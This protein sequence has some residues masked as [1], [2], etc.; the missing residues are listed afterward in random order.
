VVSQDVPGYRFVPP[1][2]V[3]SPDNP[4]NK[5]FCVS[6]PC[7]VP[8]GLFNMSACQFDSPTLISW[9]HFFQADPKLLEAVEGLDPDQEKHQFFM[10]LQP[11]LGTGLR[12]QARSQ[13]NIKLSD[14]HPDIKPAKGL[15]DIVFPFL[16]FSDGI[17]QIDDP[18]ALNLLKTAT[19]T[20]EELR[21][22]LYPTCF[23]IGIMLIL[24]VLAFWGY[25]TFYRNVRTESIT[26]VRSAD[27]NHYEMK[28]TNTVLASSGNG[29]G[30][31]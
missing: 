30:V 2:D 1:E 29:H 28:N 16:W 13:I 8:K 14:P 23:V 24:I 19:T 6:E 12:V 26:P 18:N 5:C 9:P 3:F 11:K 10:D 31:D 7:N 17:E 22:A 4:E 25:K 21:S 15:R 27:T 20:P